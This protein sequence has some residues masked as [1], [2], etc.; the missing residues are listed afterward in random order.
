[1]K[2]DEELETS[3]ILRETGKDKNGV[4]R[5]KGASQF[6]FIRGGEDCYCDGRANWDVRGTLFLTVSVVPARRK[7]M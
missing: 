1:M 2:K 6:A 7:I 4:I 5:G 3:H